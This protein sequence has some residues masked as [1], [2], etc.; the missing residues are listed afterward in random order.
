[1]N[2]KHVDPLWPIAKVF[3]LLLASLVIGLGF[4]RYFGDPN[5]QKDNSKVVIEK[6]LYFYDGKDGS[7]IVKDENGKEISRFSEEAGFARMA[8]RTLAQKRIQQGVGPEKPFRL[9]ARENGR[10]SLLDPVTESQINVD[11]FGKTNSEVFAFLLSTS[12]SNN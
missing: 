4:Y 7:V 8:I 2:E 12:K 5:D 1:M 11:A 9:I 3:L 10:I 6:Y